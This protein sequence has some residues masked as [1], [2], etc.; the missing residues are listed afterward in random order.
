MGVASRNLLEDQDAVC[1]K[2]DLEVPVSGW[3]FFPDY[4]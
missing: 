4:Y 2:W 3:D 1:S